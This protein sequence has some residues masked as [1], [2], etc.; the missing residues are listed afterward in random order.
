MNLGHKVAKRGTVTAMVGKAVQLQ[1]GTGWI[2][3]SA[4]LE[5]KVEEE[6]KRV[7]PRRE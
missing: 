3:K 1:I 5:G 2:G 4:S 6:A 7:S